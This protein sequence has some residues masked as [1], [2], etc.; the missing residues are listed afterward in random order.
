[1]KMN[2]MKK[3]NKTNTLGL[4]ILALLVAG[5]NPNDDTPDNAKEI[6]TVNVDVVL[7]LS[8]Q[9]QWQHAI[10]WAMENIAKAQQKR[11]RV[12]K[13]N[14][15]YHDEDTEDLDQLGYDLTHPGDGADSCHAIIGPYHSS[16]AND[17]LKYAHQR[18]LPVVMPTC[19]SAEL[20]RMNA[21]NTYAWFLTESDITQ[22]EMMVSAAQALMATDVALV[23]SDDIYGRSF[24][25]W[26]AYYA[27]ERGIAIA[28]PGTFAYHRGD[29]LSPFLNEI[30]RN[31]SGDFIMVLVALD[32][33]ADYRA[34][35]EQVNN[36]SDDGSGA[37][38]KIARNT[39]C[40]DTSLDDKVMLDMD[41][42]SFNIGITPYASMSY[43]FPQAYLGKFI[44]TPYS[45][46]AQIYD[47]LT[48]IALGAAYRAAS[49]T[50]CIVDGK[51]VSY[52]EEPYGPGLTDYMRAVVS[53]E[54][55]PS[56]QWDANGLAIGFETLAAGRPID[57]SGATGNLT[58]DSETHTMIL[59]TTYMI[60]QLHQQYFEGPDYFY[61]ETLPVL[62]LSTAGTSSE[63]ST[64]EFWKL[65]KK[66]H[67]NFSHEK[68]KHDLPDVTDCW[69]VIVSPSTTWSNYRHQADAFAMYQTLRYYGYD[70][71]HI[72]LI[73]EDNLA[74]DTRNLFPGEIFVERS[75]T[76]GI[77]GESGALVDDDVR[78]DAVVD[79]HFSELRP[80]D[81]ADILMGRASDVLP[82][83]IHPTA[84]SNIFF[85]WSGHGG[86]REGPLWG[87]EDAGLFFGTQRIKNIVSQMAGSDGNNERMYRRMFFAVETCYSGKW[88]EALTEQP[89]VLV[90]TAASPDETS[91][92]DAYDASLGIYLSNAFTR[93]FRQDIIENSAVTIYDLYRE[94]ARTTTGSHVTIYNNAQ[95][96]SVY[97]ETLLEYLP[98]SR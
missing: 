87:N 94:L 1:M 3:R 74:N 58:F 97:E 5:C 21:R 10:D 7:P 64:T 36:P 52:D 25:D 45:G 68:V 22:C 79:Y 96:G 32:D 67:Q 16:N 39:I 70:D 31:A 42:W 95:Y 23:Y 34:V 44:R 13:L 81:L 41:F 93:T 75:Q 46:S 80:D 14:L 12:V 38:L 60:W 84:S 4:L 48:I 61:A 37:V 78:K 59:N 40:A 65:S 56:V 77:T 62:Y 82:Q 66:W 33:A 18:R 88:G 47:A 24:L 55:G 49:P 9:E 72:V 15:R 30:A 98:K 53:S 43:G 63:A 28:E 71:D 69:A 20:Q 8:V 19:T 76:T 17:L 83:V 50:S 91:K 6:I 2:T 54:S 90:L 57:M 51:E 85:F 92:A 89:D 11:Q 86:H 29:D 26:F 27:T 73:V 35:C